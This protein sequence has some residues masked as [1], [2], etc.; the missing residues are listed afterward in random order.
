MNRWVGGLTVAVVGLLLVLGWNRHATGAGGGTP[1]VAVTTELPAAAAAAASDTGAVQ[2]TEPAD[3]VRIEHE[4]VQARTI[5]SPV[6]ARVALVAHT[7][8]PEARR[9]SRRFVERARRI[10]VGDGRYRP[11][12]FPRPTAR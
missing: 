3:S 6:S 10:I 7:P 1:A 8:R 2:A 12:P 11:E 9:D 5:V 4:L